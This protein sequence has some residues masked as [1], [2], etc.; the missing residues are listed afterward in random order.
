MS[1][2]LESLEELV[3]FLMSSTIKEIEE[4]GFDKGFKDDLFYISYKDMSVSFDFHDKY[5]EHLYVSLQGNPKVQ[6]IDINDDDV[7]DDV[8]QIIID[9]FNKIIVPIGEQCLEGV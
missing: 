4:V 1:K 7:D 3:D 9:K 2:K 8:S 5:I 6:K